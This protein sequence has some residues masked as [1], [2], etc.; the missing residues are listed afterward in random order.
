[1]DQTDM[2]VSLREIAPHARHSRSRIIV[3]RK[4]PQRRER[5][6]DS[7]EHNPC[8]FAATGGCEGFDQPECANDKSNGRLP[9]TIVQTVT[10]QPSS[11]HEVLVNRIDS[12]IQPRI[13]RGKKT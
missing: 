3:L 10:M 13:L 8:F 9:E 12:R 2:G 11:L 5:G 4:K 7:I 6:L 1:M